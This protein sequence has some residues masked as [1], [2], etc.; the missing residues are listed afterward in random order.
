MSHLP[1][2][3]QK[4]FGIGGVGNCWRHSRAEAGKY[5]AASWVW[6]PQPAWPLARD[7]HD[8]IGRIAGPKT[9]LINEIGYEKHKT[10]PRVLE[11]GCDLARRIYVREEYMNSEIPESSN[12]ANAFLI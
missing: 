3:S 12:G 5:L 11:N 2:D 8:I 10:D 6:Q 9:S 1:R 4:A 7:C